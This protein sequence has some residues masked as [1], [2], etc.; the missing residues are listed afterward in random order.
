MGNLRTLN[1]RNL[2]DLPPKSQWFTN[3]TL[4]HGVAISFLQG[5]LAH[6][7]AP[8]IRTLAF[9]ATTYANTRIGT[10]YRRDNHL[11]DFL[12]LRVYSVEYLESLGTRKI[13][14]SVTLIAQG[15]ADNAKG[16]CRDLDL[17]DLYWLDGFTKEADD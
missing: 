11:A 12:R 4:L 6:K 13:M 14:P 9:G 5:A 2:P 10:Y 3:N 7:Q 17:F 8:R 16:W 15:V 1:I